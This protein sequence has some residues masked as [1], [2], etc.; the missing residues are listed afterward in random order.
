MENK[1]S[2]KEGVQKKSIEKIWNFLEKES[3]FITISEISKRTNLHIYSVKS[4]LDLLDN[5]G[6]IEIVTNGRTT[7]IKKKEGRDGEKK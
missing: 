7:L 1:Q 5:L 6:K 4:C 2:K 3:Q